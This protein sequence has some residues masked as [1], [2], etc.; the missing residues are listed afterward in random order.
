MLITWIEAA[1]LGRHGGPIRAG[2]WGTVVL[3]T[4]PIENADETVRVF[5]EISVDE[6]P[7]GRLPAYHLGDRVPNRHWHVAIPPQAIGSR[8]RYRPI[9]VNGSEVSEAPWRETV[10]RP[11][12]PDATEHVET[13]SIGL[14]GNRRMTARVDNRGSTYDI[15]YPSVGL[16]SNVRPADGDFPQSRAHFRTIMGGLALG[17]RLDWFSEQS[18]WD[19]EQR[20]RPGTNILETDLNWRRGPIQ[21]LT[22]DFIVLGPELPTDSLGGPAS[23]QYLK[24]F[25]ITNRD[26]LDREATFG[27]FVHAEVNG[28]LG[29]P[30]LGWRDLDRCLLAANRGHG[31]SNDKLARNATIEFA[32]ALDDRDQVDCEPTAASEALILRKLQL[33]AD[34]HVDVDLLI[35]GAFTGWRG[36]SGTFEHW[37][38][39]AL[40]WFRSIDLDRIED[41][42]TEAWLAFTRR[43][44]TLTIP[45]PAFPKIV[46]R[47]SLATILHSDEEHGSFA[48]GFDR[49]INAYCWPR[50]ALWAAEMLGRLGH[51]EVNR[52]ALN[53]I[54]GLPGKEGPYRALFMKYTID[55]RPEWET[56]AI[57][58]TMLI[59]WALA[60]YLHRTG[61]F[62][63]VAEHWSLVKRAADL[64]L[65]GDGHPGLTWLPDLS[66]YSSAGLW[67]TRY[68][69]Y[70]FSNATVVAGLRAA[71]SLADELGSW[72]DVDEDDVKQ[73][74]ARAEEVWERGVLGTRGAGTG[75][76]DRVSGRFLEGR[77]LSMLRGLWSDRSEHLIEESR[78]LDIDAVGL[79]VPFGLLPASDSALTE[80]AKAILTRNVTPTDP[81]ALT[82]WSPAPE[83]PT[84]TR[85]APSESHRDS[86]SPLATLWMARYLI[87]RG[88]ETGNAQDWD[89]SLRLLDGMIER[90]TPLGLSMT[91][92][93]SRGFPLDPFTRCFHGVW[94]LHTMLIDTILDFV[95]L[96]YDAVRRS[97]HLA[98]ALPTTWP[99][100]GMTHVFQCGRVA[101]SLHRTVGSHAFRLE[102]KGELTEPIQFSVDLAC[103]ELLE[104][105]Q[106]SL[107][108]FRVSPHFDRATHRLQFKLR[109]P[110]GP[111][112]L[113]STWGDEGM[114]W[115]PAV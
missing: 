35:S 42:T 60:Q 2:M 59:P 105:G 48:A 91:P 74:E 18:A 14:V 87:Q 97:L 72:I 27:L 94:G 78:A 46:E 84:D 29:E 88:R 11:N 51:P 63:F 34:G 95:G 92:G 5:L 9:A 25:R 39:P 21:V 90:L 17:P 53:W 38:R 3:G 89:E 76:V 37:L 24:R 75:L 10:I 28:G 50:D 67:E 16:H 58:Q 55:G 102:L 12:L 65:L 70:L 40:S 115:S 106:W 103:P 45:R 101:F 62:S 81:I 33:P 96:S 43:S 71:V 85:L 98:P 108:P 56:P 93:G 20:Y 66:L 114:A 64:C 61:D 44:Q 80:T 47:S 32:L 111:L 112:R 26:T 7:L 1:A 30:S 110:A 13:T 83:A 107:E 79:A 36:D 86:P 49:G 100:L 68:G 41:Q 109:L 22:R 19:A 99:Y 4:H 73:W 6:I 8:L 82:R 23:G 69:A 113:Q 77:R 104:L 15:F 52:A 57:D 54:D 31:H